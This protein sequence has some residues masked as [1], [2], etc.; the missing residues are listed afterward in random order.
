EGTYYFKETATPDDY[1]LDTAPTQNIIIG[2][3]DH[4][5]ILTV[6]KTNAKI[7]AKLNLI[8][9]DKEDDSLIQGTTFELIYTPQTTPN[10]PITY[11]LTTG[12]DG[13]AKI[14]AKGDVSRTP[15]EVVLPGKGS[16][17]LTETGNALSGY[18][19]PTE[20]ECKFTFDVSDAEK[21][22]TLTIAENNLSTSEIG[23]DFNLRQIGT[24]TDV[25]LKAGIDGIF[26]ERNTGSVALKKVDHEKK[27]LPGATF[28][29]QK[30]NGNN[31]EDV[32]NNTAV[33]DG[34][35]LINYID[36][37]FGDYKIVET[38]A[39]PGYVLGD[40]APSREFIIDRNQVA[41]EFVSD[42][43]Q[44][45]NDQTTARIN[46]VSSGTTPLK[47]AT[48]TVTGKFK[49]G[50]SPK[51]I[52]NNE[53][54]TITGDLIVNESYTLTETIRPTGYEGFYGA[55]LFHLNEAGKIVFEANG[56]P[57]LSDGNPAATLSA[58]GNNNLYLRNIAYKGSV[59]LTKTETDNTTGIKAVKFTLY[60]QIGE[61]PVATDPK[62]K[63]NLETDSNGIITVNN[64]EEGN[65]Y[66]VETAA[67]DLYK[68]N[69]EPQKFIITDTDLTHNHT[70]AINMTN[71]RVNADVKVKKHTGTNTALAGATVTLSKNNNIIDTQTTGADGYATF[72]GLSKGKYTITETAAPAGYVLGNTPFC[73][74]FDIGDEDTGKNGTEALIL[75]NT[76]GHSLNVTS[77]TLTTTGIQN[78]EL[79]FT[80][81]KTDGTNTIQDAA[82]T[83]SG[84]FLNASGEKENKTFTINAGTQKI[85]S[86][87]LV[88]NGNKFKLAA[89][90]SYT[91]TETATPVK[92]A[93]QTGAITIRFING[94]DAVEITSATNAPTAN[95]DKDTTDKD[96]QI[97][98][99][100]TAFTA[101]AKVKKT[102]VGGTALEG[103]KFALYKKASAPATNDTLINESL[104]T[105]VKGETSDVAI[106]VEKNGYGTY[107]F[108]ET[109]APNGYRLDPAHQEF[110]INQTDTNGGTKTVEAINTAYK[111]TLNFK[112]YD[113]TDTAGIKGATFTISKKGAQP[114][115]ITTGDNGLGTFTF[116]E[117]GT[118]TL[119]E[120]SAT[121][122]N[123]TQPFS[124][125]ITVGDDD[126]DKTISV[127]EN[128]HHIKKAV[129]TLTATGIGNTRLP[130]K[131]SLTKVDSEEHLAIK[132]VEFTLKKTGETSSMIQKTDA[133]GK[134]SF[135]NLAWGT[136]TITET[137]ADGY[138]IPNGKSYTVTIDATHLN[139]TLKDVGDN[140]VNTKNTYSFGKVDENN[141]AV[142]G[143]T[144]QVQKAND[145][146]V[147]KAVNPGEKYRALTAGNYKLV[148]T[149]VPAGYAQ[150]EPIYF[151]MDQYGVM[152]KTDHEWKNPVAVAGN[153]LIM[154]DNILKVILKKTNENTSALT[155]AALKLYENY[156]SETN[157]GT[158]I[159]EGAQAAS[160]WTLQN[161]A[162]GFKMGHKLVKGTTYT[163]VEETAPTGY[164][165]ADPI[166]FT[167]KA[168]GTILDLQNKPIANKS[169][170]M[171]D[172]SIKVAI[173]KIQ[174][175]GTTALTGA[176]LEIHKGDKNGEIVKTLSG[177]HSS[178]NVDAELIGTKNGQM[179]TI[180]E[181]EAPAGYT[182]A[183]PISFTVY[184]DG[185]IKD[186]AGNEITK[187]TNGRC[188]ITMKDEKTKL[189]LHK[190]DQFGVNVPGV[191]LQ[192]TGQFAGNTS[193]TQNIQWTTTADSATKVFEGAEALVVGKRYD[194]TE[195]SQNASI[196][197]EKLKGTVYLTMGADGIV[198]IQKTNEQNVVASQTDSKILNVQNVRDMA[199]VTL[200]KV[201]K[202]NHQPIE[203]TNGAIT[204][205]LYKVTHDNDNKEVLNNVLEKDGSITIDNKGQWKSE[206][207]TQK[208]ALSGR[209]LKD[210][211]ETGQYCF[212]EQRTTAT[213]KLDSR[214]D[215][216][217]TAADN[218]QTRDFTAEN[219]KINASVTIKKSDSTDNRAVKG[220]NFTLK[221]KE[222]AEGNYRDLESQ[223]TDDQGVITFNSLNKGHYQLIETATD[224]N[225]VA[226]NLAYTFDVTDAL[227]CN[228]MLTINKTNLGV[229]TQFNLAA[230]NETATNHLTDAGITND[231]KTGSIT[232][233]K[234]D[235]VA[236]AKGLEGATFNVYKN[237]SG[238]PGERVKTETT[239]ADG[240]FT[241]NGLE[242]G[243]YLL[244]EETAPAGYI[245]DETMYPFT[246]DYNQLTVT[247]IIV[248]KT[249][250]TNIPNT[251][252]S[253][254]LSKSVFGDH[255]AEV[256]RSG[257][258]FTLTGKFANKTESSMSIT[259]TDVMTFN[260]LLIGGETY[261]LT[262]IKPP[263]GAERLTK[264]VTFKM[265]TDGKVTTTSK[266]TTLE[267][268]GTLKVR[269]KAIEVNLVKT[270][271]DGKK[272]LAGAEFKVTGNFYDNTT[273][274]I[275]SDTNPH[276]L[277]GQLKTGQTYKIAETVAPA[278]YELLPDT[279]A[280][281]VNDTGEVTITGG[282]NGAAATEGTITIKDK[283]AVVSIAKLIDN[284]M[285]STEA[286]FTLSGT[287]ADDTA[288]PILL[289]SDKKDQY[290]N[291]TDS[292]WTFDGLLKADN[293]TLYTLTETKEPAGYTL[294]APIT[295]KVTT[296]G[297]I[298][299]VS[300][301]GNLSMDSETLHVTDTVTEFTVTKNNELDQLQA[302]A[303]MAIYN[304]AGTELAT[305]KD[306]S[307]MKW[308]TTEADNPH[309]IKGLAAGH[310]QLKETEAPDG[311]LIAKP[312]NFTVKNDG[313]VTVGDQ[314]VNSV[315]MKD[316]QIVLIDITGTKTWSDYNNKSKARPNDLTLT[317]YK[318]I[319]GEK[320]VV[321]GATPTWTG[322]DTNVWTY[323]FDDLR[324]TLP[325]GEVIV[326]TVEETPVVGYDATANGNNL[327]NTVKENRISF[328]KVGQNSEIEPS[329]KTPLAGAQFTLYT[330]QETTQVSDTA[331]S[332]ADGTVVFE[333]ASVGTWFIKETTPP[334][335]YKPDTTVY[336]AIIDT[337][338]NYKGLYT[339]L[340][341]ATEI[342]T[343]TNTVI[344]GT[345]ELTKLDQMYQLDANHNLVPKN[346]GTS[347][348]PLDDAT[349]VVC[350]RGNDNKVVAKL[351]S[352]GKGT[353]KY[354]L[355][356]N[357][358]L[359]TDLPAGYTLVTKNPAGI[360]YLLN[361]QLLKGDYTIHEIKPPTGY[362]DKQTRQDITIDGSENATAVGMTNLMI[363]RAFKI[364]KW[365]ESINTGAIAEV[366][367]MVRANTDNQFTFKIERTNDS[368]PAFKFT[369]NV[370]TDQQGI[371]DFSNVPYGIYNVTEVK[372][373]NNYV[374]NEAVGKIAVTAKGVFYNDSA[375]AL[376]NGETKINNFLKRGSIEGIKVDTTT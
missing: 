28:K 256:P 83:L 344:R 88:E 255:L 145:E 258:Q 175:D 112:K 174:M 176:K 203:N 276:I 319:Y 49:S 228:S 285:K 69:T 245:L 24:G 171:V 91:L 348:I 281:T 360:E 64:L 106:N 31:Y 290:W 248:G 359:Q 268:D 376:I 38:I 313:T 42:D 164:S 111:A 328:T 226:E 48:L 50:N 37:P 20:V 154:T 86:D 252:N 39:A 102:V 187:D 350:L 199:Q 317:L 113:S 46:K 217:I 314:T 82:F 198:S 156:T 346:N 4:G 354:Q 84:N 191:T 14:T 99:T 368:V 182:F 151:T 172:P 291:K 143:A 323:R 87:V 219:Q 240:S 307:T 161:G 322:K 65:Y 366:G 218:A 356:A 330:D 357:L 264:P 54:N 250:S 298:V 316:D 75:N 169:V 177:T 152:Y 305:D 247:E 108:V 266:D 280:F 301:S 90:E 166:T 7:N 15:E 162:P 242:W 364:S 193:T 70:V 141:Q 370:I 331:I 292:V 72:T 23:K 288:S 147:I 244:K 231:R 239:V 5:Q 101:S 311:Y 355:S 300:G 315:T 341:E 2:E 17:V 342:K 41:Y 358:P 35:G 230:V 229:A 241:I 251:Q 57:T 216:T 29:L 33:T 299:I 19:T 74:T 236:V 58:D 144:L 95:I 114:Q 339:L 343:V 136:Y 67:P 26:N 138:E 286:E 132:D 235:A 184:D 12:A 110:T 263:E 347:D 210:G 243:N 234:V 109:F 363:E 265:G 373:P 18:Q 146:P 94:G 27:P 365:M 122:Y 309:R 195:I 253:F 338:G 115:T 98:V 73:A 1:A 188:N 129:G 186:A 56:N 279:V 205:K 259:I 127:V 211:L 196:S 16:Y 362:E 3:K 104:I 157:K 180:V 197:Y 34:K 329:M 206:T 63:E 324:K 170:T 68:T 92:Y 51:T 340:D 232:L 257:A 289:T 121:G 159:W 21:G 308:T 124:C 335:D 272:T 32:K 351:D 89:D 43:T 223:T 81:N 128:D 153:K 222:T 134:L 149:D 25:Y 36:L 312:I 318:T 353:G 59:T 275:V 150:A 168:D 273:E 333:H 85:D 306:G 374:I 246:I 185:V 375:V 71:T 105:N 294:A 119:T 326:Y 44:I 13:V 155:G 22:K 6:N 212:I 179:Y 120:T 80:I 293:E 123:M 225:Y 270:N 320:T 278:G 140:I 215:F 139:E 78:T 349:F 201:D 66:F 345:L 194:L 284:N 277:D 183:E 60:K 334:D 208:N 267:D 163:L 327:T 192:L 97:K 200:T 237:N 371:A 11:T 61:N 262:E 297:K 62:I 9:K 221:Y 173:H 53:L 142:T 209:P 302:N 93:L 233:K 148:E 40:P 249:E 135:D 304:E 77:G 220:T 287:F 158:L 269:D 107:Y 76:F 325:N 45:T 213:Y 118:Y 190:I 137:K 202:D 254:K 126:Y 165:I 271:T 303:K 160:E 274:K 47:G 30:K 79:N 310:Y 117:K 10:T 96:L 125:D 100:N 296:D 260:A 361:G 52:A 227:D 8:K 103:A 261:T 369:K 167:I 224:E 238:Q 207:E 367:S 204:F 321:E 133:S 283:T 178:W 116:T 181:A 214:T 337:D 336:K 130:G 352:N 295:F 55:V 282:A 189:T 131:I 332:G 372:G